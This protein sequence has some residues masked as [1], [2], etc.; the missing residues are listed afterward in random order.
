MHRWR[1]RARG[2]GLLALV[3]SA[4][5]LDPL[6]SDEVPST[7]LILPSGT[8]P[9]TVPHLEDDPAQA[10]KAAAFTARIDYLEGFAG[11]RPVW[12]WTV[13][14]PAVELLAPL[15]VV[16]DAAGRDSAPIIDA[17]PGEP[18]YSPWWRRIEVR[19][20]AAYAGEL[21]TSRRAI[22]AALDAGLV[23]APVATR[24]IVTAVVVRRELP[25]VAVGNGLSVSPSRAFVKGQQVSWIQ[26]GHIVERPLEQNELEVLPVYILQRIDE[27]EPLYEAVAG[28]DLDGD[29]AL[30][31]SNN[32]FARAPT[33][34]DYTPLWRSTLVRVAADVRSIDTSSATPELVQ[35]ADVV[36]GTAPRAP[37]VL[38]LGAAGPLVNCPIQRTRGEL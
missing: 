35:E 28:R 33:D 19:A 2:A 9:A 17:L 24:Q 4:G 8:D 16:V 22:E 10:P 13:D 36:D 12:Y 5:C 1:T 11:G 6:V 31:A 21:L 32:I 20:T 34:P 18:G 27:S 15:Y 30:T 7:G 3:A 25:P 23:E 26:F 38:S 14:G 29:G 37:R